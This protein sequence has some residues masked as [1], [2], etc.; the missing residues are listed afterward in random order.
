MYKKDVS[1]QTVADK[2]GITKVSVSKAING[3]PGISE[4]LRKKVLSVCD[5][6]G[7]VMQKPKQNQ[8]SHNFCVLMHRR[9]F[10]EDEKFYTVILYHLNRLC[11]NS[12]YTAN[13]CII[14]EGEEFEPSFTNSLKNGA[15]SGV[16]LLGEIE[17]RFVNEILSYRLPIV[18]IDFNY[19]DYRI[20]H[21]LIDNYESIQTAM[22]YLIELGHKNFGFSGS[23]RHSNNIFDRYMGYLKSLMQ[24]GFEINDEWHIVESNY[25][26]SYV[27]DFYLPEKLPTVFV[28]HCD[29]A[30]YVLVERLKKIGIK[31]PEDISVLGFD[32]T[33]IC[34]NSDP[35]I[36]SVNVEK[37]RLAQAAFNLMQNR[38]SN[39]ASEIQRIMIN[40]ELIKRESTAAPRAE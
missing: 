26:N 10:I 13:F 21:V 38:L 6:M 17:P 24:N 37:D 33:E 30:A 27:S 34:V 2:L 12:G 36:T 32:N 11:S 7:Y 31:V 19:I 9:F 8:V 20:D 35:A 29:K 15:I 16:F 40:C 28:C 18:A 1:M 22:R 14:S 23:L 4:E 25:Y 3:Q 39:P 5:E